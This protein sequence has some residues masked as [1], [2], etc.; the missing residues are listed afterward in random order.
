MEVTNQLPKQILASYWRKA[1]HLMCPFSNW[2]TCYT[3]LLSWEACAFQLQSYFWAWNSR[4]FQTAKSIGLGKIKRH[5]GK[6]F[7]LHQTC[8]TTRWPLKVHATLKFH[9]LRVL[10]GQSLSVIYWRVWLYGT[11]QCRTITFQLHSKT[12]EFLLPAV[13]E[14]TIIHLDYCWWFSLMGMA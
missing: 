10:D 9:H 4:G 5:V 11:Y 8:H 1:P 3:S 2:I 14:R 12:C 7:G 13:V 6:R